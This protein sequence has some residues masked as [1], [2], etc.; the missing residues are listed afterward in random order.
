MESGITLTILEYK[1]RAHPR[2]SPPPPHCRSHLRPRDHVIS[3]A[4]LVTS[5]DVI[6]T[7]HVA[8]LFSHIAYSDSKSATPITAGH[9]LRLRN[10]STSRAPTFQPRPKRRGFITST[11]PTLRPLTTID[12]LVVSHPATL[13]GHSAMFD[14]PQSHPSTSKPR[15]VS[16]LVAWPAAAGPE[17]RLARRQCSLCAGQVYCP[18]FTLQ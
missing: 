3:R 8:C 10:S 1:V 12:L 17:E 11:R 14:L 4:D 5:M 7:G 9:V 2:V 16:L 15:D 6:D 13:S 18:P